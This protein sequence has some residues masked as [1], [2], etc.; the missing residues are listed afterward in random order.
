MLEK[1]S[2]IENKKKSNTNFAKKETKLFMNLYSPI[3]QE[4]KYCFIK[5][6]QDGKWFENAV[7][8]SNYPIQ[9]I[10]IDFKGNGWYQVCTVKHG[11]LERI[12]GYN[13]N[14]N[15][16]GFAG[17]EDSPIVAVRC[18][19]EIPESTDV[20]YKAKYRVS[21]LGKDWQDFVYNENDYACNMVPI[22]R[23]EIEL[24]QI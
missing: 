14:D 5:I 18:H 4:P 17:Y 16:N 11:W 20:H 22:D 12:Y 2:D 9:A 8:V 3:A 13:T 19:Y 10:A 15:E 6:K 21:D 23:L 24:V 7:G 1:P